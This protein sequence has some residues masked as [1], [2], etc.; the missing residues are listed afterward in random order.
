MAAPTPQLPQRFAQIKQDIAASYPDFEKQATEAWTE[1]IHELNKAAETIGSQGPDFIPQVKFKDLDNLDV[2]TIEN[3]R[4]VGTV[5]I[6]DIVDDPD[7]IKWREELKTFVKEHPEVDGGLLTFLL[8]AVFGDPHTRTT[9]VPEQDKQ[10]FHL[11]WTKPQV[12]ARSHPNLLTATKWLNQLYRSNSDSPSAEL[13]GVDLS[14]P[15]TYADRF[16]IRHPGK[17]WDLHPPHIDGA[18]N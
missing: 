8:P 6:R 13:D 12:Q 16:R 9:G 1:I 17:A 10:F 4:R 5:V 15:L 3:I 18:L 11:F 7:A 2:A 14:T